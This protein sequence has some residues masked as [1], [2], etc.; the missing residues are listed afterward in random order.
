[1]FL[2]V[3]IHGKIKDCGALPG[4]QCPVCR[5]VGHLHL[6]NKYM[7]PHL[8]FIHTFRFNN[9]YIV[10]CGSCV[11]IMALQEGKGRAIERGRQVRVHPQDLR[12]LRVGV[13]RR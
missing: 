2:P 6:T 7:T 8:F 11:S 4:S 13:R 12:V 10:T 9:E 5:R 1:M 3:G